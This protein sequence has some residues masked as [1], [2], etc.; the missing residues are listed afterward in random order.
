MV[1][2]KRKALLD[3]RRAQHVRDEAFASAAIFR[4]L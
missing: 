3:E 2:Q 1:G 4:A